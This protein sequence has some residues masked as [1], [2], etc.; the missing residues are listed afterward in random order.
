MNDDRC[1]SMA[2]ILLPLTCR[3][4]ATTERLS[5]AEKE[6]KQVRQAHVDQQQCGLLEQASHAG[7]QQTSRMTELENRL[8]YISWYSREPITP[9]WFNTVGR[10]NNYFIKMVVELDCL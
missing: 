8:E 5:K 1:F 6:L 2:P 10:V 9:T 4:D 3:L 7:D